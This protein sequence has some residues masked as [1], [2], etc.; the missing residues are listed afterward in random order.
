MET[1]LVNRADI[2]ARNDKIRLMDKDEETGLEL[3][4]YDTCDDNECEL[5]KQSRGVVFC[6][7]TLVLKTF[8]WSLELPH[9]EAKTVISRLQELGKFT[10]CP[11]YEGTLLRM[12]HF[13]GKWYL[14]THRKLNA[15]RSRWACKDTFGDLFVQALWIEFG[16]NANFMESIGE[17]NDCKPVLE[18][19]IFSLFQ[20]CLDPSLQYV[21]LLRA[22]KEN[23]IACRPLKNEGSFLCEPHFFYVG[24]FKQ[25]DEEFYPPTPLENR[26]IYHPTFLDFLPTMEPLADF[27][28]KSC[29]TEMNP[30]TSPEALLQ[31]VALI[32]PKEMQGYICFASGNR[33]LKIV[34]AN[35]QEAA[36]VR[37]DQASVPYRYLQIRMDKNLRDRL[38]VLYPEYV[39][40]FEEYE[41][42]LLEL[43]K[44]IHDAYMRR[45]TRKEY[46]RV[47]PEQNLVLRSCH[48]WYNF[49]RYNRRVTQEQVI[50][51]MNHQPSHILNRMIKGYLDEKK[52]RKDKIEIRPRSV[53][54]SPIVTPA[55]GPEFPS[56]ESTIKKLPVPVLS[57]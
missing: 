7:D 54:N 1:I 44:K 29:V 22:T 25:G 51:K 12:F 43:S 45:F 27:G 8:P 47:P 31:H 48:E 28:T 36:N 55:E 52:G 23:R 13:G 2:L 26:D 6:G 11:A 18:E 15:F 38:Y 40:K 37:G 10:V 35:Y 42:V 41:T 3:Y 4:C 16:R 46:V 19:E 33:Q 30:N 20:K 32:D 9:T 56:L 24:H 34:N 50:K 53:E 49:D 21:F 5:V 57:Q 39:P 14:A 17:K